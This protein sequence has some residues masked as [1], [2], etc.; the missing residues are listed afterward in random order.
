MDV[1]GLA[2]LRRMSDE[3]KIDLF[4]EERWRREGFCARGFQF[5]RLFC[6]MRRDILNHPCR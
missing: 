3:A 6:I 5:V 1:T 2:R 4:K